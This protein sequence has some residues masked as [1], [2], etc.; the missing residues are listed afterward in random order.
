MSWSGQA[1]SREVTV[2]NLAAW[3]PEDGEEYYAIPTFPFIFAE[4]EGELLIHTDEHPQC[5]DPTCPC[6][7]GE[8]QPA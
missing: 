2:T 3:R 7:S 5:D 1:S 4:E 8:E 6:Q